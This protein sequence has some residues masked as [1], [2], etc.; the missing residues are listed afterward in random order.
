[1]RPYADP[2]ASDLSRASQGRS[3]PE[4]QRSLIGRADVAAFVRYCSADE[5]CAIVSA[6]TT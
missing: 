5:K 3:R 4:T 1:M 6:E 2:A